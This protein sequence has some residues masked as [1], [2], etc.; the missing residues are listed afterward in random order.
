M[1]DIVTIQSVGGMYY[2]SHG[3][4]TSSWFEDKHLTLQGNSSARKLVRQVNDKSGNN[5]NTTQSVYNQQPE[6]TSNTLNNR[7]EIR[8]LFHTG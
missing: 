8:S 6:Y 1:G 7:G 2:T 3:D 4:F 5:N